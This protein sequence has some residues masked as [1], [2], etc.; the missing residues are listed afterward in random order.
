MEDFAGLGSFNLAAHSLSKCSHWK[1]LPNIPYQITTSDFGCV[2][3]SLKYAVSRPFPPG[4]PGRSKTSRTK[5]EAIR[6]LIEQ[7]LGGAS[8]ASQIL[9][10]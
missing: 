6:R 8:R 4:R 10:G 9:N 7:A 5:A 2:P 1:L 3:L